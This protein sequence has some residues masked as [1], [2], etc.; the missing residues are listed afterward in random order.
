MGPWDCHLSEPHFPAVT[1]EEK[2]LIMEIIKS[3]QFRWRNCRI[4]QGQC[5]T[6]TTRCVLP[7]PGLPTRGGLVS[8][9]ICPVRSTS[10][11]SREPCCVLLSWKRARWQ[12]AEAALSLGPWG[13]AALLRPP[14]GDLRPSCGPPP[15]AGDITAFL[16]RLLPPAPRPHPG[17][18]EP[19]R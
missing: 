7:R 16:S 8:M 15:S 3:A 19:G 13:C 11:P 6:A 10:R 18:S 9:T 5:C 14:G 4:D 1:A 2:L 12:G 17:D